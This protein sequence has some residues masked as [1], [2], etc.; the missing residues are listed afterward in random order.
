MCEPLQISSVIVSG[1]GG[2]EP[3]SVA[4]IILFESGTPI[5]MVFDAPPSPPLTCIS[6]SRGSGKPRHAFAA[7]LWVLYA[8][9]SMSAHG[10][11]D[12]R[13]EPFLASPWCGGLLRFPAETGT[14]R[15]SLPLD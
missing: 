1:R 14:P 9:S 6:V 11:A 8:D 3:R 7:F 15:S 5:C 12:A 2:E 4:N 10:Y 13:T